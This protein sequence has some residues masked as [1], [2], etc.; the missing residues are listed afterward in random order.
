[1]SYL[2]KKAKKLLNKDLYINF[3]QTLR[4]SL[5]VIFH[6]A[7][8]F[9]DLIH[10]KRGSYGAANFILILTLLTHVWK[11][12]FSSFLLVEVNWEEVNLFM[13]F[14]KILLP[15]IIFVICNWGVT[16]LFDGKGHLGDIYKGTADV[17][18]PD[19][20]TPEDEAE[21]ILKVRTELII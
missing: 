8:G 1:M 18:V 13:E 19:M 2:V 3:F 20:A 10:A 5:Y 21:F 16:T 12:Q 4:Y 6:P 17:T 11:L 9:W 15:F 14:A 7:D